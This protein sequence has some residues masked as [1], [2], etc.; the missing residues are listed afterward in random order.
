MFSWETH[1]TLQANSAAPTN[2]IKGVVS[3]DTRFKIWVGFARY[4]RKNFLC[5]EKP[6]SA[7]MTVQQKKVS[8]ALVLSGTR[9]MSNPPQ[10]V[11][12]SGLNLADARCEIIYREADFDRSI[13]PYLQKIDASLS[14]YAAPRR[15]EFVPKFGTTLSKDFGKCDES[16]TGVRIE[17]LA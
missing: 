16:A 13:S 4:E 6:F 8:S 17:S 12:A 15:T 3:M 2:N 10:N 14:H 9:K 7:H 5:R 1:A 11:R